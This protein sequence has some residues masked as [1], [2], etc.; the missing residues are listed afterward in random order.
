MSRIPCPSSGRRQGF[1][2]VELLVAMALILFIMS[3]ISVAFVD[4]TESFRLFRARAELSEKLRFITQTL[5]ADLRAN[6]FENNRRLSDPD[7][8]AEGPPRAGYFRVEQLRS[9]TPIL[10]MDN[11]PIL[12]AIPDDK[13]ALMFTSFLQGQD[14][15]GFHSVSDASLS[16]LRGWLETN[17]SRSDS[18]LETGNS[19]NSPDAEIG[20][21]LGGVDTNTMPAVTQFDFAKNSASF[22]RLHAGDLGV[23]LYKLY[24]RV[25]PMLPCEIPSNSS[26]P[27]FNPSLLD[28]ISVI[29]PAVTVNTA[30]DRFNGITSQLDP[31][32]DVPSRRFFGR[33]MASNTVAGWKGANLN[34]R[35]LKDG[36][37]AADWAVVADNVLSFSIEIWPEGASG[38]TDVRSGFGSSLA[39]GQAVFDTWCGRPMDA[40]RG[41]NADFE[42]ITGNNMPKWRDRTD[43]SCVPMTAFMGNGLP[44]RL[45]AVRI[46][47]RLYDLNTKSTWQATVIEYL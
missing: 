5:R 46:T 13:H 15:K 10:T 17:G 37:A 35:L 22:D 33:Y 20:W 1:T 27:T 7:F 3:I 31:N 24:R 34:T 43:S 21:F 19:Y 12:S 25:A 26:P 42:S 11:D 29:P 32:A 41:V 28:R 16:P 8:W 39:G 44:R 30:K 47:I 14:Y 2:L 6:H 38:F 45:L 9:G 4:S 23:T 18:R 40:G 36:G